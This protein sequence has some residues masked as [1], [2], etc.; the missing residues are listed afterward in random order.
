MELITERRGDALVVSFGRTTSLE[1]ERSASFKESIREIVEAGHCHVVL[2]LAL[3]EFIDSQGLGALIGALKNLRKEGGDLKL[4][5]VPEV[6][7][8][9]LSIT[10]LARIFE[11]HEEIDDA[12]GAFV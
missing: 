4:V 9:V 3:V 12:V 1:G 7:E 5:R 2:D 10:K 11:T 8:A 6:V